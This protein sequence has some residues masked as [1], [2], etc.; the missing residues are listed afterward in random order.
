MGFGGGSPPSVPDPPPM[1]QK[2]DVEVRERERRERERLAKMK[3]RKSTIMTSSRGVA[4][5]ADIGR[6]TLLGE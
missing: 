4:E 1:P 5:E 6:K 2:S 3:G